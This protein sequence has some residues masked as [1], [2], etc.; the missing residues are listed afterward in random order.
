VFLNEE[1]FVPVPTDDQVVPAQ[2]VDHLQ[3]ATPGI[4]ISKQSAY[5]FPKFLI[6]I[7]DYHGQA[8][9]SRLFFFLYDLSS[10]D[11]SEM[12]IVEDTMTQD[13]LT[14]APPPEPSLSR[15]HPS[16]VSIT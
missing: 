4:R 8:V 12:T 2:T 15:T 6:T 16:M 5:P 14:D 10:G 9:Y 1:Q 11:R 13:P 3:R 7:T